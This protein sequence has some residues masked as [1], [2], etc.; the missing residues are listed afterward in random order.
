MQVEW[1]CILSRDSL[2]YLIH[3]DAQS[4][5]SISM[6]LLSLPVVV[7]GL[8]G[9]YLGRA[10]TAMIP[11]DV[12]Q[13]DRCWNIREIDELIMEEA[14]EGKMSNYEYMTWYADRIPAHVLKHKRNRGGAEKWGYISLMGNDVLFAALKSDC[15]DVLDMIGSLKIV[16]PSECYRFISM[17]R[18]GIAPPEWK[19]KFVDKLITNPSDAVSVANSALVA[20]NKEAL[21]HILRGHE[22]AMTQSGYRLLALNAL[23][24]GDMH[25]LFSYTQAPVDDILSAGISDDTFISFVRGGRIKY[26][27]L[28][29]IVKHGRIGIFREFAHTILDKQIENVLSEAIRTRNR[30]REILL[31]LI[32]LA[33]GSRCH[34]CIFAEDPCP[35]VREVRVRNVKVFEEILEIGEPFSDEIISC[36]FALGVNPEKYAFR[37]MRESIVSPVRTPHPSLVKWIFSTMRNASEMMEYMMK[38]EK[39]DW[40]IEKLLGHSEA[41]PFIRNMLLLPGG[42]EGTT[43]EKKITLEKKIPIG[44]GSEKDPSTSFPS[45]SLALHSFPWNPALQL[46]PWISSSSSFS[47]SPFLSSSLPS[48]PTSPPPRVREISTFQSV[49]PS[50]L[51]STYEVAEFLSYII[52]PGYGSIARLPKS[53]YNR[54]GGP[55]RD[56]INIFRILNFLC[57]NE[58]VE[59]R[60]TSRRCSMYIAGLTE[61]NMAYLGVTVGSVYC[62]SK[63]STYDMLIN[64]PHLLQNLSHKSGEIR[65]ACRSMVAVLKGREDIADYS[66]DDFSPWKQ[67]KDPPSREEISDGT[68]TIIANGLYTYFSDVVHL[69]HSPHENEGKMIL[70]VYNSIAHSHE[71]KE[72]VHESKKGKKRGGNNGEKPGKRA[73]RDTDSQGNLIDLTSEPSNPWKEVVTSQR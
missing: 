57:N 23:S 44:G 34:L 27:S 20:Q 71:E 59:V 47:Q 32:D 66:W 10:T 67:K 11:E 50:R 38:V 19:E 49:T 8:I 41:I 2:L 13:C 37:E 40:K 70:G 52:C 43:E 7:Q 4:Y 33:T 46:F 69:L 24:R 36:F 64:I 42:Y 58:D 45:P 16:L 14:S 17:A 54:S 39:D 73:R 60:A 3:N 62:Y 53:Y 35:H 18:R 25:S 5:S 65:D 15:I 55:I 21:R 72:N 12:I 48:A 31:P 30:R 22:I 28:I 56:M 26:F 63:A 61:E 68:V 51:T 9:G 6:S 1:N 29:A